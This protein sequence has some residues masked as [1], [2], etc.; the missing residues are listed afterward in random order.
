MRKFLEIIS[1]ILCFL[2]ANQ[3]VWFQLFISFLFIC[4]NVQEVCYTDDFLYLN[5]IG[6]RDSVCYLAH[7]QLEYILSEILI[8][9]RLVLNLDCSRGRE[10]MT[11]I[12]QL[13]LILDLCS[14]RDFVFITCVSFTIQLNAIGYHFYTFLSTF[15]YQV[16]NER[17]KIMSSSHFYFHLNRKF[18][19]QNV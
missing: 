15:F 2:C 8:T 7:C 4:I 17:S 14:Q 10:G 5:A 3:L 12:F 11:T 1:R 13:F 9:K 16:L 6:Y 19:P 18:I